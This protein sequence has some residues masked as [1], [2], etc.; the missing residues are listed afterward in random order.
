MCKKCECE[1]CWLFWERLNWQLK[2]AF[3]H[4]CKWRSETEGV[5]GVGVETGGDFRSLEDA[6]RQLPRCL[7]EAA[8]KGKSVCDSM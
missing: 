6:L 1:R 4:R 3:W 7:D 8:E 5:P 2:S